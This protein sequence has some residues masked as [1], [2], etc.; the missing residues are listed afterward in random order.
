MID[1]IR[2]AKVC[3]SIA[4]VLYWEQDELTSAERAA[5]VRARDV[6]AERTQVGGIDRQ[7]E[8]AT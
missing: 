4:H 1:R 8:P 5:L 3:D 2:N 7:L 6:C